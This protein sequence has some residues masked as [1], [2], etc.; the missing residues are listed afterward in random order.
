MVP[1]Y[2]GRE[3][4]N[5]G[6]PRFVSQGRMGAGGGRMHR[7]SFVRLLAGT[8]FLRDFQMRSDIPALRVVSGYPASAKP[9]MPGPY[10]GRVVSIRSDT[11]VDTSTGAANDEVVREMMARGMRTLTGAG[12]T[13]DASLGFF[14]PSDIAGM[15]LH[16][17]G[18][19]RCTSLYRIV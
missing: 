10:P 6:A 14:E 5:H 11:C 16:S 18:R 8:P 12:T 7:R 1:P 4:R 17:A 3:S 19:P 13:A 15:K 9:G 2:R